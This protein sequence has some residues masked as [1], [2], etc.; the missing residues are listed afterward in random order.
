MDARIATT[1]LAL[2]ALLLP[3][4]AARA[5]EF[6]ISYA[7]IQHEVR[8]RQATWTVNKSVKLRLEGGNTITE[9]YTSRNN[10]GDS[11]NL[12]G[13]GRFRDEMVQGERSQTNW[14]V[15]D[16]NTLVR[17]WNRAQHVET[18]R[19]TVSGNTCQ[20]TIAYELK[21]GFKEYQTPSIRDGRPLYF[22]SFAAQNITC[23]AVE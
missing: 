22:S 7:E 23:R 8:P 6:V 13:Q 1:G 21:P 12:S 14:R 20:A 3:A 10:A 19:V 15:L 18:I 11:V 5:L 4:G 9:G 17:T 2:A 16:D